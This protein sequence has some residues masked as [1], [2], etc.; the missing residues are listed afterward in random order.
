MSEINKFL[1]SQ[2]VFHNLD[3]RSIFVFPV[4]HSWQIFLALF[5]IVPMIT[6]FACMLLPESPKFLMSRGRNDEALKVFRKMFAMNKGLPE[7]QYPVR[8]FIKFKK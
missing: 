1:D 7:D 2:F 3:S 8:H 4:L 5:S 6:G